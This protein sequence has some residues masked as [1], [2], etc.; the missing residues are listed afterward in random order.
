MKLSIIIPNCNSPVI[1]NT[2]ES[3]Y[4]SAGI[5]KH[6]YEIILCDDGST[7]G[8]YNEVNKRYPLVRVLRFNLPKG[9]SA[10]RNN[11]VRNSGG[12]I[13]LFIDSDMWLNKTTITTMIK[14]IKDYDIVFPKI[15]Y[16]NGQVMYPLLEVEKQ[17]PHISGCFL[18]KKDALEKLDEN[19]DEFYGTYLED[20]DFFIRCR[21]AGLSASY[22]E[23]ARVTHKNK[24]K[25][26]Y[27]ERYYLEV[28]NL[29]Y[30]YKKLGDLAKK[31]GLYNPFTKK[32]I[33]KSFIYGAMNFA[34][35]NWHGYDR[36]TKKLKT[37]NK[38]FLG[39]GVSFIKYFSRALSEIKKEGGFIN[40]KRDS[41][42]KFYNSGK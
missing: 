27:S 41:V 28:R 22:I 16:E 15:I 12:D 33:A 18:I 25:T 23:D 38:I 24:E 37:E 30:G 3:I 8:L 19:F 17:Y 42:R 32:A 34:W 13:L 9:A 6:D 1:F 26:D 14:G 29:I 35:F 5:N 39:R 4:S 7:D 40:K 21:L 10:A 31:S 20:Y 36:A 11:G 2:V